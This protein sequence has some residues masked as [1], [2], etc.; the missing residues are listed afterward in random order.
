MHARSLAL[1]VYFMSMILGMLG[2]FRYARSLGMLG[3]ERLSLCMSRE[4]LSCFMLLMLLAYSFV[5]CLRF[6]YQMRQVRLLSICLLTAKGQRVLLCTFQIS[7]ELV[8]SW[9]PNWSS[10]FLESRYARFSVCYLQL[11]HTPHMRNEHTEKTSIPRLLKHTEKPTFV[12]FACVCVAFASKRCETA[13][14]QL[15]AQA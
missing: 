5:L 1:S 12:T 10:T 9:Q 15:Q 6:D 14:N 8:A 4:R 11:L 13:Q 7:S 2:T 3:Y